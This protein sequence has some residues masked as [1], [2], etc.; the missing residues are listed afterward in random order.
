MNYDQ[1][2]RDEY[3]RYESLAKTVTTVLQA[4]ID[5]QLQRKVVS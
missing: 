2:V 5:A 1:F 3:A 4:A